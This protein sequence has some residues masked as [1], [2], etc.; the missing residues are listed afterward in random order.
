MGGRPTKGEKSEGG[1][2]KRLSLST[3]I[4]WPLSPLLRYLCRLRKKDGG[5]AWRGYWEVRKEGQRG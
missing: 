1:L 2:H 5:G 4:E 3:K